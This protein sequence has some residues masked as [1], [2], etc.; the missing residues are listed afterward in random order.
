MSRERSH[1]ETCMIL[2]CI[3]DRIHFE[4]LSTCG[5]QLPAKNLVIRLRE[6]KLMITRQRAQTRDSSIRMKKLKSDVWL[7]C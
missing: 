6:Q 3:N 5:V 4:L 2:G 1:P 7:K